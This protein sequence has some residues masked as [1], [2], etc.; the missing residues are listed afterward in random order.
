MRA[1]THEQLERKNQL[2]FYYSKEDITEMLI[3]AETIIDALNYKIKILEEEKKEQRERIDK[4]IE[5]VSHNPH[6][7]WE[8]VVEDV[9]VSG[10][11]VLNI[12]RG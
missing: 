8:Q 9:L 5:Y 4:A 6:P 3:D 7:E 2:L 11:T 10:K 12:L 1:R